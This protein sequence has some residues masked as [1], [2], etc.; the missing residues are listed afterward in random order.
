MNHGN[1]LAI[2]VLFVLAFAT[3]K[4]LTLGQS[5]AADIAEID[6][7]TKDVDAFI[8]RN[9]KSRRIF[10]DAAPYNENK[11]RWREFKTD[12]QADKANLYNSAYVWTRD[13]KVIGANFTF[14]SPSGDWAHFVMYY[15]REDGSLAKIQGRLNTFYGNVSV[16]RNRYFNSSGTRLSSTQRFLDLKTQKPTKKPSEYFDQPEPLYRKVS[17]L[18]FHRLL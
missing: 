17:D 7:Y 15:F 16:V 3:F 11:P 14:S 18:P 13:G 5:R 4:T 2:P 9:S 12:A 1:R 6:S 8:K 10:G